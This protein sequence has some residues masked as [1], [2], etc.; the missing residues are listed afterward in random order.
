M[1]IGLI[2]E[3]YLPS[4]IMVIIGLFLTN[5]DRKRTIRAAKQQEQMAGWFKNVASCIRANNRG[6]LALA[7]AYQNGDHN[8]GLTK[9]L[10]AIEVADT[11]LVEFIDDMG[12]E[13][14]TKR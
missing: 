12:F 5:Q 3:Q 4:I 7:E 2:I 10:T 14:L 11:K 1:E 9:A 13:S 8:G 6:T